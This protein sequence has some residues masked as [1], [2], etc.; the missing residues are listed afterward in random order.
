[1]IKKSFLIF[2]KSKI[3]PVF[4]V[5]VTLLIVGATSAYGVDIVKNKR[6]ES[7]GT[8][9]V[10][11]DF[12]MILLSTGVLFFTAFVF[13]SYIY[14]TRARRDSLEECVSQMPNGLLKLRFSQII[15]M[16]CVVF[17]LTLPLFIEMIVFYFAFGISNLPFLAYM[18]KLIF[19]FFLLSGI[20]G[21]FVGSCISLIKNSFLPYLV[22]LIMVLL[23]FDFAGSFFSDI[24][25]SVGVDLS[26]LGLLF[27]TTSMGTMYTP[28]TYAGASVQGY[29]IASILFLIFVSCLILFCLSTKGK[30][31][32]RIGIATV[33]GICT[34][35]SVAFVLMP[36]STMTIIP[37]G[38]DDEHA[39]YSR[40]EK[41]EDIEPD[42]EVTQYDMDLKI[43]RLL[44]ANVTMT[45]NKTDLPKYT[46]TLYHGYKVSKVTDE[47]KNSLEFTQDVDKLTIQN[48]GKINKINI[49]YKG[50]CNGFY[51]N[52]QA[53]NL[54]A[55]FP[56]YPHP[57]YKNIFGNNN[58]SFYSQYILEN[59]A[60]FNVK[61]AKSGK[62]VF[63]NLDGENGSFSGKSDGV[64]LVSA[65][66]G[67]LDVDG[68]EVVY[69]ILDNAMKK[70]EIKKNVST[71]GDFIDNYDQ[72]KKIIIIPAPRNYSNRQNAYTYSD[73]LIAV[74]YSAESVKND[75]I[76]QNIPDSKIA[77]KNYIDMHGSG[78]EKSMS[79]YD[80]NG[81][82][83]FYK[84]YDVMPA[85][86]LEQLCVDFMFNDNDKRTHEEFLADLA[87]EKGVNK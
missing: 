51:S 63:S 56:Y 42:F 16:M 64:T 80:P 10:V 59:P 31:A 62:E 20:A 39:Y 5:F 60:Q 6:L 82:G 30:D 19:V 84:L 48:P 11:H 55:S 35:T 1:M 12:L 23:N 2:F 85:E 13:F 24:Y 66:L 34:A 28:N 78:V 71:Y 54:P 41:Q 18:I 45:V 44:S 53:V 49:K 4:S 75:Y 3:L 15:V 83:M 52:T 74:T 50:Y 81:A 21:A 58:T 32:K 47:N 36:A 40:V 86:E 70:D 57:G 29:Q 7:F 79:K 87:K 77:L 69:P 68:K 8:T 73:H 37:Q 14:F 46:M 17:A 22:M 76:E 67:T 38:K 27:R 26:K 65:F 25:R 61:V 72:I 43:G 9:E 33:C